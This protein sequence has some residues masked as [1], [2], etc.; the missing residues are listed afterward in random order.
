MIRRMFTL[1]T[2]L[3]LLICVS[4]AVLWVRSYWVS[5]SVGFDSL[6]PLQGLTSQDNFGYS[7]GVNRGK[8]NWSKRRGTF[9]MPPDVVARLPRVVGERK[10]WR[11]SAVSVE[12]PRPVGPCPPSLLERVGFHREHVWWG[13]RGTVDSVDAVE[14]PLWW[15]VGLSALLPALRLGPAVRRRRRAAAHACA[16]CGYDLRAT[17]G[18]CPEC[19]EAPPMM[20]G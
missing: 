10:W 11:R 3:S 12:Y 13:H 6:E 15:A 1:V 17:P 7:V 14:F 9:G 19:G 20:V 5:D 8:F 18:R 2:A 4:T 16:H